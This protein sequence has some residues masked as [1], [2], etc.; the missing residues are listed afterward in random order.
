MEPASEAWEYKVVVL[1]ADA[2]K[3]ASYLQAH[4]PGVRYA[5]YSPQALVPL[6][7]ALGKEGWELASAEAVSMGANGDIGM[8]DGSRE[9][10]TNR[11]LCFFKRRT[12][13]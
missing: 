13:A 12:R 4:Y 10:W 3:Q 6:L 11:Y 1:E 8:T 5:M 2:E 7:N 9:R